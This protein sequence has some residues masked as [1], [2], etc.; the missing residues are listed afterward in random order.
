M[1]NAE[2][3]LLLASGLRPMDI[4]RIFGYPESTVYNWYRI[5]REA[6]VALKKRIMS[7]NSLSLDGRKQV[8][9]PDA[10]S[11]ER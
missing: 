5:Y 11:D 9:N 7:I 10:L 6:G 3:M 4:K 8:N 2:I 1:K